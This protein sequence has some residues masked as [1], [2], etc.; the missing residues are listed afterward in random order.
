MSAPKPEKSELFLVT[1]VY[2][3]NEP[4][5]YYSGFSSRTEPSHVTVEKQEHAFI[6]KSEIPYY[7]N[8]RNAKFYRV[9]EV[10]PQIR[11]VVSVEV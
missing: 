7:I 2:R 9:E 1:Y 8:R 4:N 11:Q 10:F 3:Y 5:P 6:S